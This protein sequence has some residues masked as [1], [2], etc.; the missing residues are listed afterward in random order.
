MTTGV[1]A[2]L[3]LGPSPSEIS[4]TKDPPLVGHPAA[5][6][7]E[8]VAHLLGQPRKLRSRGRGTS[9]GS[10][11]MNFGRQ[12]T[13]RLA[14]LHQGVWTFDAF[15]PSLGPKASTKAMASSS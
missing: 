8:A 14:P 9:A 3:R 10:H 2:W 15:C 11:G 7:H 5:V 4:V 1:G 6:D 12:V 13:G